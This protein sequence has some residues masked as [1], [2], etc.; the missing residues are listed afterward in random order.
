MRG[1]RGAATVLVVACLT[2]LMTLGAALGL[3]GAIV[4]AHRTA[5]AAA[6]LAALAG[7]QARQHGA[8]AC[9]AAQGVAGA[10]G[11]ELVHCALVG[12]DVLVTVRVR[13]PRWLGHRGDPE[14]SARAGPGSVV[15][16]ALGAALRLDPVEL[17]R[18]L[19]HLPG[20]A[21]TLQ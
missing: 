21:A 6:D 9:R 7:A 16:S 2:L 4:G 13:G 12:A 17:L 8:D 10:N 15:G 3:V 14:A 11:A 19:V 20:L 18:Q 5:Q 1:D